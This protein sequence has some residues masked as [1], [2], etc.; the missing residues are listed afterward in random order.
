MPTIDHLPR[1]WLLAA[2]TGV[3]VSVLVGAERTETE[4]D[5]R[6]IRRT[7]AQPMRFDRQDRPA[8]ASAPH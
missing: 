5:A 7:S 2:M 4:D 8:A 1:P 6:R 3:P